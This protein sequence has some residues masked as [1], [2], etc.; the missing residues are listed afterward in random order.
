MK[1]LSRLISI[2]GFPVAFLLLLLVAVAGLIFVDWMERKRPAI[3]SV[4]PT[5]ID[6][7]LLRTL[8]YETGEVPDSL[9]K[10]DGRTVWI[11]GFIV[12]LEDGD[13]GASEFLLIPYSSACVHVASAPPNMVIRVM[14]AEGAK[15]PAGNLDPIWAQGILH[16]NTVAGLFR[17]PSYGMQASAIGPLKTQDLSS[18][19]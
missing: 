8:N 14:M 15:G 16:I 13:F 17:K 19:P 11:A 6:W 5:R 3:D 2:L 9:R 12:P 4:P 10:L 7:N 1:V 18:Q